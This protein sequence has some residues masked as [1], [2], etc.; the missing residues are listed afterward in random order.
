MR[1]MVIR[2]NLNKQST[3]KKSLLNIFSITGKPGIT[4]CR[5]RLRSYGVVVVTF[6]DVGMDTV[7][8][9]SAHE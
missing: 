5:P 7:R 2:T 1:A 3:P 4:K 9:V 6:S 8:R